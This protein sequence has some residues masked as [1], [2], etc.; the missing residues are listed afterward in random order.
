MSWNPEQDRHDELLQALRHIAK[1][2][3]H[4]ADLEA[5]ALPTSLPPFPASA[6]PSPPR[7]RPFKQ[8]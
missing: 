3:R 4:M 6:T 7:S 8:L 5:Q 1:E 2:I